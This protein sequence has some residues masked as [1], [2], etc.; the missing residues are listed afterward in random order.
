MGSRL[1]SKRASTFDMAFDNA[2]VNRSCSG[3]MTSPS[4]LAAGELSQ[5]PL[6]ACM[7]SSPFGLSFLRVLLA[8]GLPLSSPSLD[9]R[10]R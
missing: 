8:Q 3:E 9:V 2:A 5:L 6:V 4:S 10:N 7:D 1:A